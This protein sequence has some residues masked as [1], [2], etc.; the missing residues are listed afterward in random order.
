MSHYTFDR[1]SYEDNGFLVMETP[2]NPMH[3]AGTQIF[4]AGPLATKDGGIDVDSIRRLTE[5]VLH[6]IPRYRQKL[7]T[8]PGKNHA[9]WVDDPHF[10]LDYHM[11][12]T[13]LPRPGTEAQLK[14]LASRIMEQPLDRSRPLWETW[15]MEGL[16][17]DRFAVITKIHHCMIDGSAG[18]DI[19][20]I[21]QSPSPETEIGKV[22]RFIPRPHPSDGELR[23][24]ARMR[25]LGV[26][27]RW[28]RD[29][30]G[31]AR[32]REKP[33]AEAATRARAVA[34]LLGWQF[35]RPSDTPIN[36]PVSP[37]RVIDWLTLPLEDVKAVRRALDCTVNDVVMT[38]VTGAIRDFMIRRQTR[39]DEL[40]FRA[41]LPVNVRREAD[42][43]R[44]GNHVSTWIVPLPL[45]E[46]DPL[47][48]LSIL[49]DTT[50]ALKDS[51]QATGTEVV[52]SILDG[53]PFDPPAS[54]ASRS[55]NTIVTNVP[56]PQF[57]L[58]LLGAEMLECFPH[59]PLLDNMGLTLGVLSYNGR[60]CF[61][62]N[63]DYD[64]VP[65]LT[66]FVSLTRRSFDR[67]S[68]AAGARST[69]VA[70]RAPARVKPRKQRPQAPAPVPMVEEVSQQP[71][72]S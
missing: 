28:A 57:P 67:L 39:P 44:L 47:K 6:R 11:R 60:M 32:E 72:R 2:K 70:A 15:I 20:Q 66:D 13:S 17:G 45:A 23:R 53:L 18:V 59:A 65:D 62:F 25:M 12:H 36:G 48:Q 61:G 26:P 50:L 35:T 38:M 8:I 31:F 68:D 1:L 19:S 42:S 64:R 27:F 21:L 41:S 54:A 69:R 51:Q 14:S 22:P 4:R 71:I 16:E 55:V 58:Y 7:A 49:H 30:V 37:H 52:L 3:V 29:L 46:P 24:D 56:G 5:S 63:A 43:G 40:D 34:G 9:V 33:L 10:R